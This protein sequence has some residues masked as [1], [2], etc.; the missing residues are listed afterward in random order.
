MKKICFVVLALSASIFFT[1]C[2]P[3]DNYNLPRETITMKSNILTAV[4]TQYVIPEDTYSEYKSSVDELNEMSE[5][6]AE[7]DQSEAHSDSRVAADT[8]ITNVT[9]ETVHKETAVTTAPPADEKE[10]MTCVT[11]ETKVPDAQLEKIPAVP[12]DAVRTAE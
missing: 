1:A 10:E 4:T 5:Y 2:E 3:F 11:E 7:R 9:S 6:I 8:A 12:S